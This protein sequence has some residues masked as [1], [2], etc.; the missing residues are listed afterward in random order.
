M[1]LKIYQIKKDAPDRHYKI[2]ESYD[3]LIEYYGK[4]DMNDYNCVWEDDF[5][6]DEDTLE[7]I[8]ARF[9]MNHPQGF[10]G[11]SLSVSDIVE[12]DEVKYYCDYIGWK[13]L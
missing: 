10:K 2:F 4:I 7:D 8:F 12:M 3:K 11:H 9:N 5:A 13:R 6:D 1:K